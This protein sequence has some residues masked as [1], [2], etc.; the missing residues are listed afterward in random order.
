MRLFVVFHGLEHMSAHD[1]RRGEALDEQTDEHADKVSDEKPRCR[2]KDGVMLEI[3]HQGAHLTGVARES[4][5]RAHRR[6]RIDDWRCQHVGHRTRHGQTFADQSPD[7]G[8]DRT[9]A[10]RKNNSQ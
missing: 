2:H 6:D 4:N 1:G 8:H 5:H 9:F 7:D 3:R 10:N